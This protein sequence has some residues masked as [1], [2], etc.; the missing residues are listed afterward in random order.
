MVG[1]GHTHLLPANPH[2]SGDAFPAADDRHHTHP[3]LPGDHLFQI[4]CPPGAQVGHLLYL[5]VSIIRY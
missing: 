4:Q 1:A 2:R 3:G 5:S